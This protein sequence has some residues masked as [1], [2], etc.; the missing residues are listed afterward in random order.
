MHFLASAEWNIGL[1]DRSNHETR[2]KWANN[3]HEVTAMR[4]H[5]PVNNVGT[6]VVSDIDVLLLTPFYRAVAFALTVG[7]ITK[8]EARETVE[9]YNKQ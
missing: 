6:P 7:I 2:V 8:K 3:L 1:H 4:P 9:E 5:C